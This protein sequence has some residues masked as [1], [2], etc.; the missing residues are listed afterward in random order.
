MKI[1][2]LSDIEQGKAQRKKAD[3]GVLQVSDIKSAVKDPNRANIFINGKYRLS[4]NLSQVLD[5]GVKIGLEVSEDQLSA[6]EE[7]SQFGKIY[8][9]TLEYCLM[10]PRSTGEVRDYL[11]RKTRAQAYKT[12]KGEIK[13]REGIS[14]ELAEQVLQKMIAK[15]YVNDE[16][17]A[18]WWV[19]NRFLKK[20]VSARRLRQDLRGKGVSVEI[21]E[22]VLQE[23]SRQDE[24]ELAKILTKKAKKYS[25]P[26]KLMAYLV[27]QGFSYDDVKQAVQ[28]LNND[29]Y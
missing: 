24:T 4:L 13:Q 8:A 18:R 14:K 11:W 6:W 12:R 9:R 28:N 10:R 29:N 16:E 19:E 7:A 26:Q 20:G 22:R 17:F 21:I 23:S 25:D 1:Q 27:R 15:K 2:S 5:L 3:S